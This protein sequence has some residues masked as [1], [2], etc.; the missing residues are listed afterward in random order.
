MTETNVE[1]AENLEESVEKA[2]IAENG[3]NEATSPRSPSPIGGNPQENEGKDVTRL[4]S[5]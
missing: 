4:G 5:H 3:E 2:E 1:A